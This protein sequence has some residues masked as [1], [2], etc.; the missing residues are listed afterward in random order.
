MP[1]P[2]PTDAARAVF[3][4]ALLVALAASHAH[5]ALRAAVRHVVE[6]AV[7]KGS[8]EEARAARDAQEAKARYLRSVEGAAAGE[9]AV[10]AQGE[11]EGEGEG[12]GAF[13]AYDEGL[14]EIRRGLK[15]A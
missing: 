11:R 9:G 4:K 15:E 3:A 14:E 2:V 6:R 7:W 12:D 5:L 10:L 8:A 13:W 1:V